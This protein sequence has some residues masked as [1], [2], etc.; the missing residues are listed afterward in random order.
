[1]SWCIGNYENIG[2]SAGVVWF[3]IQYKPAYKNTHFRVSGRLGSYISGILGEISLKVFLSVLDFLLLKN[4][5]DLLTMM[6]KHDVHLLYTASEITSI[7]KEILVQ[8]HSKATDT[9]CPIKLK[10]EEFLFIRTVFNFQAEYM[11]LYAG[12]YC[13]NPNNLCSP[14]FYMLT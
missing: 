11:F 1:M 6:F 14:N 4:V 9:V 10:R 3:A 8:Y 2:D 7:Y 13:I 12:F 5:R